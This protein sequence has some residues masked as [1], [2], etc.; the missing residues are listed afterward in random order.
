MRGTK[1]P[2]VH[3]GAPGEDVAHQHQ[4]L[5]ARLWVLQHVQQHRGQ[6]RTEVLQGRRGRL[7][8]VAPNGWRC[9]LVVE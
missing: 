2:R 7:Q 4:R 6:C 5:P 3:G 8:E 9:S 1:G